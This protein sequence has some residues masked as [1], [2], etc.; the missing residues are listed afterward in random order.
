MSITIKEFYNISDL[1][2]DIDC[3]DDFEERIQKGKDYAGRFNVEVVTEKSSYNVV[4]IDF[5]CYENVFRV[6]E[7]THFEDMLIEYYNKGAEELR[8]TII[9]L[10]LDMCSKA[11]KKFRKLIE[12]NAEVT[13]D[14]SQTLL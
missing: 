11:E 13:V 7:T 14:D 4:G 2:K 1:N 12:S 6:D 8:G 9:S 3:F 10:Y 5:V